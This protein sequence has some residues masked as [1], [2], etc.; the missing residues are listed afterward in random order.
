[1]MPSSPAEPRLPSA[2]P[3]RVRPVDLGLLVPRQRSAPDEQLDPMRPIPRVTSAP[4]PARRYRWW[5]G[6]SGLALG[7]GVLIIAYL[8]VAKATP[9]RIMPA[10]VAG[11]NSFTGPDV[12]GEDPILGDTDELAPATRGS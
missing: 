6:W 3:R 11:L 9:V 10:A 5:S 7:L 2:G 8:G 1:M 4:A 12:I